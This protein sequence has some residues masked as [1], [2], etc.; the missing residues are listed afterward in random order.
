[1]LSN[2]S[3]SSGVPAKRKGKRVNAFTP[4]GSPEAAAAEKRAQNAAKSAGSAGEEATR[5]AGAGAGPAP[6]VASAG[7]ARP[8]AAAARA[9]AWSIS[10]LRMRV[11]S[12]FQASANQLMRTRVPSCR[13]SGGSSPLE[14]AAFDGYPFTRSQN[15]WLPTKNCSLVVVVYRF[16]L[17]MP[18]PVERP[19]QR[20]V[21]SRLCWLIT[22]STVRA[23][24]SVSA[25]RT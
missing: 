9:E 13:G 24:P 7:F 12:P 23:D 11:S 14:K 21:V 2:R 4:V 6:T 18:T 22:P 25:A 17:V 3:A 10:S 16:V 19:D 5:A 1:M 20:R 8:R 15:H